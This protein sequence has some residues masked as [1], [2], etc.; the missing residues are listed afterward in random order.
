MSEIISVPDIRA[1]AKQMIKGKPS[2]KIIYYVDPD[3]PEQLR[4]IDCSDWLTRIGKLNDMKSAGYVR[5]KRFEDM[6]PGTMF[7]PKRGRNKV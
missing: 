5:V 2:Q 7:V 6:L 4:R 3:A 1:T